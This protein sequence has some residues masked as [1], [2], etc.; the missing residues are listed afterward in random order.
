[1][2]RYQYVF[3][4]RKEHPV[5]HVHDLMY[6]QNLVL[7]RRLLPLKLLPGCAETGPLEEGLS[8]QARSP[9]GVSLKTQRFR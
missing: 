8:C 9:V 5:E 4:K 3:S 7:Q 1:M 6:G 2:R